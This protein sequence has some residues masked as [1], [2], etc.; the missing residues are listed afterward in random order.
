MC[1]ETKIK[2]IKN[3]NLNIFSTL[4]W[5]PIL[6]AYIFLLAFFPH[7]LFCS[8]LPTHCVSKH[9]Q[10][11]ALCVSCR[12]VCVVNTSPNPAGC[13]SE[14]ML[15]CCR[16]P[17]WPTLKTRTRYDG[18][19]TP[20]WSSTTTK[21]TDK[22]KDR[23]KNWLWKIGYKVQVCNL[24]NTVEPSSEFFCKLK[25]KWWKCPNCAFFEEG[26]HPNGTFFEEGTQNEAA[27]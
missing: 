22:S 24:Q 16:M 23:M 7:M 20:A 14:N 25:T 27:S 12:R 17:T 9:A 11:G 21:I 18:V 15:Y 10:A 8:M 19:H 26:T 5:S 1:S 3:V 13:L 2:L 6:H 4:G